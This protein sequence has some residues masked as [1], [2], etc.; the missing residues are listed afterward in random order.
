MHDSHVRLS[1]GVLEAFS[2]LSPFGLVSA[3]ADGKQP[4]EVYIA[5]D[6]LQG[7]LQGY[8]ASP[9][10]QING[11]DV[12]EFLTEFA[13][14]NA[15]GYLEPHADWNSLMDNPAL[16]V[17]GDLSMFQSATFYPG[18]ELNATFKNGSNV[19][20]Y[21]LASYN[22]LDDTG[23]LTTAGDFYNYFVLGLL[24]ASYNSTEQW[25]PILETEDTEDSNST[26]VDPYKAICS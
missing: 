15:D 24:P 1:A 9:V 18:D 5:E 10:T 14:L 23:P 6:L 17:S 26:T 20:S 7:R 11:I 16:A 13:D 2:F 19:L 22:E 8:A 3:S 12:V 4:P 25:W 21:W